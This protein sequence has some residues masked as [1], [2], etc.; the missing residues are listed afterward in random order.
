MYICFQ[1]FGGDEI[2][3]SAGFAA[4]GFNFIEVIFHLLLLSAPTHWVSRQ[5]ASV[6][7]IFHYSH[8]SSWIRLGRKV[9]KA[10]TLSLLNVLSLIIF[11]DSK[12]SHL[13]LCLSWNLK[14]VETNHRRI[15]PLSLKWS[16]SFLAL[17][18]FSGVKKNCPFISLNLLWQI[19]THFVQL[20]IASDKWRFTVNMKFKNIETPSHY[21]SLSCLFGAVT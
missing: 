5:T 9:I 16:F 6:C 13:T 18:T 12:I 17:L 20:C 3:F 11:I 8:R 2:S 21:F 7:F 1:R 4:D 19:F 14:K 15:G 10:V